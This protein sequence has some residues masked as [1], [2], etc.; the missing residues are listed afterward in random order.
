MHVK[1]TKPYIPQEDINPILENIQTALETGN[2]TFN[3]EKFEEEFAKYTGTKY[4]VAVNSGTSAI[5]APL[6]YYNIKG[7]NVIVPTNTFV[8]SANAV[9]YAGGTP[10]MVDMDPNNL[11][12]DFNDIK[13]KVNKNTA[14]IIIVHSCGY[15]PP[16]M[17]ELKK[18]CKEKGIFLLEDAAHAHGASIKGHKAGSIGE[19]GSFSFF[20]TKLMTTGEGG[21]V[22]T[23]NKEIA[24]YVKQVRHHGQKNGLMTEMG[25]NWRMP[26]LSA[27]LGRYQLKRLDGFIER[28]NEIASKYA[29]AFK[30]IKEIELIKVPSYI[31]HG[32]WKYPILLKKYTAKEFQT[33]LKEKYNID[34]GTV[35]YPPVHL[36]PYYKE[37]YG[38]EEGM[39]PSSEKNLIREICLPIFVD[40]TDEQLNYV[41]ESVKA[42]LS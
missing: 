17:F 30:D 32:Y 5:E 33:L 35:Y 39:M 28:R 7:K 9:V 40:I 8:A 13:R 37:N 11:C 3:T 19:I 20:P 42:E 25:Y 21:M 41:I 22:T 6:R 18:Y 2:L 29:E 23:N 26:Q 14:G 24:D 34:T 38:Y 15:I 27:I 36:Q 1:N 31:T 4:A 10:V 12:A 16:Y